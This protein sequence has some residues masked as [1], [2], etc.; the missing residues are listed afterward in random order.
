M[1]Y[2]IN[3]LAK[4]SRSPGI[5]H[6]M[7]LIHLLRYLSQH[8]QF[9]ITYYSKIE[10]SPVH[11]MLKMNNITPSRNLFT[12]SDSSWDDDHDTSRST[13]GYMIFYQ[14]GVVDH[15][16]NMPNPIAMSSAEAE[17][18]ECCL[19]CMATGNM[20]MTLNHIEGIKEGSP[21]DKP[22]DIFMDNKSAVDMSV[23]FK[24]TKNARHICRR[25]HFVKQG[26][27]QNWHK[28]VW[29]SNQYM[30]ADVMTKTLQRKALEDQV[31]WFMKRDCAE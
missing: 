27:E 25:F 14:G 22:I 23:T 19:A 7:A 11:Q 18:N 31:Q 4:F 10:N 20:H 28:L 21:E 16:S 15:S 17:Y 9:G 1:S 6:I 29:I 12:F 2:G 24:D 5:P 13:G 26:V 8:T 3:K 30:V